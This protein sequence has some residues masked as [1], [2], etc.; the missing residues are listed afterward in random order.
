MPRWLWIEC[1]QSFVSY[2]NGHDDRY[3][4]Y[5]QDK[6]L[7]WK[8]LER[9]FRPIRPKTS[10]K[11]SY[12]TLTVAAAPG[13]V[14][15]SLMVSSDDASRPPSGG[16]SAAPTSTGLLAP[17]RSPDAHKSDLE[18][19]ALRAQAFAAESR[20]AN[21][22]RAYR[23][24]FADYAAWCA[25]LGLDVFG[26]DAG[27]VGMY[28]AS[29]PERG[30]RLATI[31]LRLSAV[32]AAHRASGQA[33]DLKHPRIA[34]VMAGIARRI[35]SRPTRVAPVLAE[36]LVAM[37]ERLPDTPLGIRDRALLVVGFGAAL[38][39][40]E[41]VALDL[42][43][44]TVTRT[45]LKVLIRAS[46]ADQAGAGEEVGISRSGNPR[47]C[48]LAT[49][50]DWLAVRGREPGPFLTQIDK[51]G[52]ANLRRLSDRA[53]ARAVKA[54]VEAVGLDPALYS[55]HSLRAGL[56]TS[57]SNAGADLMH[58]MNQTRHRSVDVARRYVRD[59]E[60]WRNN[61]TSLLLR[62]AAPIDDAD[63]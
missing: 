10:D 54:A 23:A 30:L 2:F 38:R 31:R 43:D 18:G 44:L 9:T 14:Y 8:L 48:P 57:A 40:S 46:K 47:L 12:R 19:E 16:S 33:L 17:T 35:G 63:G 4:T 21:T 11:E 29:L 52:R 3:N 45:G 34:Q 1:S 20:A 13:Q 7:Y 58:I 28:L 27:T 42:A 62:P 60:I 37:V 36:D 32:A 51:S 26:A 6:V 22:R 59:A 39:R 50:E 61:V 56:A 49:L 41:L 5:I 55:G 24:A 53:V 25:R 15:P